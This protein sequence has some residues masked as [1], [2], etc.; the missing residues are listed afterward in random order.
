MNKFRYRV[1]VI[2]RE[3]EEQLE[4]EPVGD[5]PPVVGL[6]QRDPAKFGRV[7]DGVVFEIDPAKHES[8][9]GAV[10]VG[11]EAQPLKKPGGSTEVY[12]AMETNLEDVSTG[13]EPIHQ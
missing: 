4:F 8:V 2:A 11:R 13:G 9:F 10:A 6:C 7:A 1:K 3:D 5:A 12:T